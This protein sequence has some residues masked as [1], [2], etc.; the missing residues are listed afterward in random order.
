MPDGRNKRLTGWGYLA[1]LLVATI[2]PVMFIQEALRPDG[3]AYVR[4]LGTRYPVPWTQAR[5]VFGASGVALLLL[6]AW[7]AL[8]TIRRIRAIPK[9][10]APDYALESTEIRRWQGRLGIA[11]FGRE[12]IIVAGLMA[13]GAIPLAA[14]LWWVWLGGDFREGMILGQLAFTGAFLICLGPMAFGP[15]WVLLFRDN[16][17]LYELAGSLLI[18]DRRILWCGWNG[19]PVHKLAAENLLGADLIGVRDGRGWISLRV[20]RGRLGQ[21]GY[22]LRGV[23]EPEKALAALQRLIPSA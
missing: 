6:L 20:R 16:R 19:E 8:A 12:R 18:T 7:Q 3:N 21:E 2:F 13:L 9:A 11:S 15:L 23:P 14:A 5:I 10:K 4:W 1:V 22:E 17:W